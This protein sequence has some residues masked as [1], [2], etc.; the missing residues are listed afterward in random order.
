MFWTTPHATHDI[1]IGSLEVVLR[2][3]DCL[4]LRRADAKGKGK[5]KEGAGRKTACVYKCSCPVKTSHGTCRRHT[6]RTHAIRTSSARPFP[7]IWLA[8]EAVAA[9]K[10]VQVLG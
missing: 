2:V 3:G 4:R 8:L 1:A 6:T 10:S 7:A 9:A 5:G